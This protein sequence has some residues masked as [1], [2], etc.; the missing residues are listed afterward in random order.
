MEKGFTGLVN[1]GNTCYLNATLQI[2]S[3][4][5]ELN[6]YIQGNKTVVNTNDSVLIREWYDLYTLMWSKNCTV[7]PNKFLY[8][9]FGIESDGNMSGAVTL[10]NG[11]FTL[12]Q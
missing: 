8:N 11:A 4:I 9:P 3:H 10:I 7:S 6:H 12:T 1:L 2:L 5:Y